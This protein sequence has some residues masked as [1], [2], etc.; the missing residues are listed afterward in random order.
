MGGLWS[1]LLSLV[2]LGEPRWRM[3]GPFAQDV[4]W[5]YFIGGLLPGLAAAAVSYWLVRPLVTSYQF[6]RRARMLERA[7]ERLAFRSAADAAAAAP[8]NPATAF[9]IKPESLSRKADP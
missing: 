7:R 2:G 4:L 6:R 9:A 1:S 5:P 3:L 8:Y